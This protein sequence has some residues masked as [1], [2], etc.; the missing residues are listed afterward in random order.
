MVGCMNLIGNINH[1]MIFA[2]CRCF[3]S[4]TTLMHASKQK[5]KR[6]NN[7][8]CGGDRGFNF[9]RQPSERDGTTY[10]N[11][12]NARRNLLPI[13]I[14]SENYAAR[15]FSAQSFSMLR[16]Q[17]KSAILINFYKWITRGILLPT[18]SIPNNWEL[19]NNSHSRSRLQQKQ[20]TDGFDWLTAS[21]RKTSIQK[22][23]F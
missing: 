21:A 11:E 18:Q 7:V 4:R 22:E 13:G 14:L 20:Q 23:F 12:K 1:N 19:T 16:K 10:W 9:E 17:R 15:L 5:H 3:S 6:H 2:I 8:Y